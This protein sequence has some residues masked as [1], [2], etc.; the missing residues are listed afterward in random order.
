MTNTELIRQEIE[1]LKEELKDKTQWLGTPAAFWAYRK[2]LAFIDSLP[3]ESE[4]GLKWR[5][6]KPT[7]NVI[8]ASVVF[9]GE[10]ATYSEYQIL[11]RCDGEYYTDYDKIPYN[12]IV[13]W[14]DLEED[15]TVT[16]IEIIQKSWYRQ[17][18]IDGINKQEPQWILEDLKYK[19]NPKYGQPLETVTDCYQY[20]TVEE[21]LDAFIKSGKAIK[22]ENC[23]SYI[24]TYIDPL[25]VA[26]HFAKWGAEHRDRFLNYIRDLLKA[27][28]RQPEEALSILKRIDELINDN[29]L[30]EET[31]TQSTTTK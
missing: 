29:T 11:K 21:E 22:E 24:T 15:E 8:V 4:K 17:G 1:R 2:V 14:A 31:I 27:G 9:D 18:Y 23:G 6:D 7:A 16:D 13:K 3:K 30:W 5:T 10:D 26:R 25:K 19:E 28:I 20:S 12:R